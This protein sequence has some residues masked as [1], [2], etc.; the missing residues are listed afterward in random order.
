VVVV[1]ELLVLP[2]GVDTDVGGKPTVAADVDAYI[3]EAGRWGEEDT[4]RGTLWEHY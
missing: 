2:A 3:D 1:V 4:P